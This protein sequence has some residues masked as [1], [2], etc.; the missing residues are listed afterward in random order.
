ML[1]EVLVRSTARVRFETNTYSVP[2][3]Y[4]G[5]F[6]L[7]PYIKTTATL[8]PAANLACFDAALDDIDHEAAHGR[9]AAAW[10]GHANGSFRRGMFLG[11]RGDL[12]CPRRPQSRAQQRGRSYNPGDVW[13]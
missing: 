6:D 5:D 8:S 12:P 4:V 2:V 9:E 7:G 10:C 3:R 1:R 13:C 11:R